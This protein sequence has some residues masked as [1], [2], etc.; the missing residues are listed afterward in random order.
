M[1]MT[2]KARDR[3][4]RI[5]GKPADARDASGLSTVLPSTRWEKPRDPLSLPCAGRAS[6]FL[7]LSSFHGE[8]A[9]AR[10]VSLVCGSI[11]HPHAVTAPDGIHWLGK[12]RGAALG[13][14]RGAR[15]R[16]ARRDRAWL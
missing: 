11:P 16:A 7:P 10:P 15:G 2:G 13:H 8:R 3:A 1:E 6:A 9:E 4:V 14:P 12:R 5:V